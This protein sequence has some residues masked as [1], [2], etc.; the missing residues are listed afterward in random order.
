MSSG[1]GGYGG[2]GGI[3]GGGIGGGV[4]DPFGASGKW[5]PVSHPSAGPPARLQATQPIFQHTLDHGTPHTAP[6]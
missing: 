5:G 2:G 1:F 4:G 6:G 3:G